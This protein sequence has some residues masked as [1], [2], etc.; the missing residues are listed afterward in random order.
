MSAQIRLD[1]QTLFLMGLVD[2]AHAAEIYR[3]GC[4]VLAATT[5]RHVQLDLSALQH[6]NTLTVALIVQWIRQFQGKIQLQLVH[7]PNQLQA[8]MRA[9]NLEMLM[10]T[11]PA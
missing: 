1:G 5:E 2:F 6:S 11:P 9:S 10:P 7:I 8:I 3:S 4:E